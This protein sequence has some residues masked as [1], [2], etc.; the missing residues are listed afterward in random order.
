M[1]PPGYAI[2][3]VDELSEV[4]KVEDVLE[5]IEKEDEVDMLTIL[6]SIHEYT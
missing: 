4:H 5:Y 3:Y 6:S 2:M 1:C